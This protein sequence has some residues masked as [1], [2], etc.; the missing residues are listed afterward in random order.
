M[1]CGTESQD[2]LPAIHDIVISSRGQELPVSSP[3]QPA[4]FRSVASQILHLVLCDSD[5]VVM[6]RS[7]SAPGRNHTAIPRQGSNSGLP[8][9]T[10]V[11]TVHFLHVSRSIATH[12]VSRHL[13]HSLPGIRVPKLDVALIIADCQKGPIAGPC[14]RADLG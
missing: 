1:L 4:Y 6:N 11:Y 3:R 13:S 12:L 5:I 9:H 7:I 8:H 14:D 2:L 10:L